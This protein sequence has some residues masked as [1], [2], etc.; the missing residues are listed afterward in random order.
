MITFLLYVVAYV[1]LGSAFGR[2]L[3]RISAEVRPMH[4]RVIILIMFAAGMIV[5][6]M[7]LL[8][9]SHPQQYEWMYNRLRVSNPYVILEVLSQS[10]LINI[11]M[12]EL[13]VLWSVAGLG[14]FLNVR[15][16][17][18]GVM[19]VLRQPVSAAKTSPS[20]SAILETAPA[21]QPA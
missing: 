19:E 1:G 9:G 4:V 15:P 10:G 8:F 17:W 21:E 20:P 3:R 18:V 13:A 7:P 16:M 6:Y 14:L 12:S 11:K 5:P 2:A